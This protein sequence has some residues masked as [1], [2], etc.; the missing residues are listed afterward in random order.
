MKGWRAVIGMVAIA[1]ALAAA[2]PA[3]AGYLED[4]GW[5]G[6]TVLANV[7][8]MPAKVVYATVGGITGGFVYACTAGDLQAA[9]NVWTMSMGG[10]Y[11][12]TPR[13]LQGEDPIAFAG[14]PGTSTPTTDTTELQEEQL[15]RSVGGT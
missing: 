8:Y 6:L 5:G 2:R 3:H 1:G 4:A 13:M 9:E 15:G 11:V 10:T 14:S 12:V 7:F